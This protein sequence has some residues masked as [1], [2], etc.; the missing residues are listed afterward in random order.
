MG[1]GGG[2][3]EGIQREEDGG[4]LQTTVSY[5][6]C[7]LSMLHYNFILSEHS[8]SMGYQITAIGPFP[9]LMTA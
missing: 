5:I 3:G 7:I 6:I 9:F 2:G 1:G 8:P 4:R